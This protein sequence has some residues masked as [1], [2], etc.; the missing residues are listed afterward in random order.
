M[1]G[2][3]KISLFLCMTTHLRSCCT[4]MPAP[5]YF[6]QPAYQLKINFSADMG[7]ITMIM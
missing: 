3:D 1:E 4:D 6:L 2:K 5:P 7:V